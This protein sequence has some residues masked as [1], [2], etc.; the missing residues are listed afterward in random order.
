MG[1]LDRFIRPAIKAEVD[2]AVSGKAENF[3]KAL[4]E[5]PM[6][7]LQVIPFMK[8]EPPARQSHQ[9]IKMF[10]EWIYANIN[11]IATPVSN[12][13]YELYQYRGGEAKEIQEHDLL[14][15]LY[16]VNNFMTKYD[17][18]YTT[19]SHL[20]LLGEAAWY[21]TRKNSNN[22]KEKPIEIWPLR[23]DFLT[24]KPGDLSKNEFIE[25]YEYTV[26]NSDNRKIRFAPHEIL[27]FKNTDPSNP[28]R[29]LSLIQAAATTIDTEEFA[30]KWNRNFFW[31]SARPDAILTT[32]QRLTDDTKKRIKD[33]W[34]QGFGG[35]DHAHKLAVLEQGLQ[36]MNIQT[37]AKDMDF[38]NQQQWNR[39]KI[40]ALFKN[41]KMA[42][43][44]VEDV[45]RANAETSEYVH[46]KNTIKPM[47]QRLVDTLNEFLVPIFSPDLFLDF[48]DP[49]PRDIATELNEFSTG[50]NKWLTT[51][52][53]REQKG[54]DPVE[55][56]DAIYIPFSL[57]QIGTSND[58]SQLSEEDQ[59]GIVLKAKKS[60]RPKKDLSR[61][62]KR[63]VNRNV[64]NKKLKR[65]FDNNLRD[66]LSEVLPKKEAIKLKMKYVNTPEGK[67][68]YWKALI[69]ISEKFIK[70][71]KLRMRQRVY[72]KLQQM[73]VSNLNQ[74]LGTKS[75]K[76]AYSP[77]N[78]D[79]G[80][81]ITI[82]ALL[83]ILRQVVDIEGRQVWEFL[84]MAGSYDP[85]KAIVKAF[86]NKNT[87]KFA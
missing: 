11:A 2:L 57:Q 46:A 20:F 48:V 75:S 44:I 51:N 37:S 80:V 19:V 22:G 63:L 84:G 53:I 62:I 29:G 72:P 66:L 73:A 8:T 3:D 42:L 30:S 31:N 9:Y 14:E 4:K 40:M 12:I 6:S 74:F 13:E 83:P 71:L 26:P 5:M 18:L 35:V 64:R 39:D 15:L 79:E 68:I 10:T 87:L 70:R 58:F 1:L 36:Y 34:N 41:T 55:G 32:E 86:L 27:F 50:W 77:Y 61:Y 85:D 69:G 7:S 43:G 56:G 23:P 38:L 67:E 24:I 65:E 49:V 47:M 78:E 21:L 59:K 54:L 25:Y 17:L 81:E 52:E 16:R 60:K 76:K 33:M 82:G 28:Y 45:N